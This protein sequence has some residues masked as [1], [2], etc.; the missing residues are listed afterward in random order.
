MGI[1]AS[2][3]KWIHSAFTNLQINS[4]SRPDKD[5][6]GKSLYRSQE[7]STMYIGT[8]HFN[9]KKT[10]RDSLVI[11]SSTHQIQ[12]KAVLFRT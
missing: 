8:V 3:Y 9:Q 4:S 6:R 7:V 5:G 2:V 11:K 10:R 1:S 12:T